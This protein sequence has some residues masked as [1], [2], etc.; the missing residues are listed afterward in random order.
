M[1]GNDERTCDVVAPN[2]STIQYDGCMKF[3]AIKDRLWTE[4]G[5]DQLLNSTMQ[6]NLSVVVTYETNFLGN[7]SRWLL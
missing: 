6:W 1:K 5:C 3:F 7:I 2:K 4:N